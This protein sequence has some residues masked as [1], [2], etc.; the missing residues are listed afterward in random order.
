MDDEILTY[1]R[2]HFIKGRTGVTID[3]STPLLSTGIVDSF[4]ILELVSFLEQRFRVT[5]DPRVHP[6]AELDTAAN[7][8]A[9]VRLLQAS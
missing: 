9:V 2:D 1:V 8:A 6:I 4:G 3:S 5:L 7:I